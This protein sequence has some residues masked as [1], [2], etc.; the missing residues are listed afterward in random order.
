M[1]DEA[2]HSFLIRTPFFAGL[3][4]S[5]LDALADMLVSS[6]LPAGARVFEEGDQ[7][8]SLFVLKSGTACVFQRGAGGEA[9]VKLTRLG[10]GD[11][12]G[13]MT[14]IEMQPR[15]ASVVTES[16]AEL[17]ELRSADL[18]KLYKIDI[19]AYVLVL[20]NTNRELCR[21]LRRTNQR[22]VDWAADADD[23]TT[24]VGLVPIR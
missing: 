23:E 5:A 11:F 2:L 14:L 16:E 15:S 13:E 1:A 24:Q 4:G 9:P 20:Q 10:P 8:A 22:L 3:T 19:K 18:Y 17:L 6:R 12:F 7:G 21:R